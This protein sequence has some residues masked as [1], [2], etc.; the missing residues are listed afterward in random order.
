MGGAGMICAFVT[1][2]AAL[3]APLRQTRVAAD[4]F[5]LTDQHLNAQWA[6]SSLRPGEPTTV[7]VRALCRPWARIGSGSLLDRERARSG[8]AVL[9]AAA[10]DVDRASRSAARSVEQTH[11]RVRHMGLRQ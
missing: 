11:I 8:P 5:A 6:A 1:D 4:L 2:G 3:E 7:C 9:V 10:G